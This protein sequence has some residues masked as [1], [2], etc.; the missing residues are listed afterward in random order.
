[1]NDMAETTPQPERAGA[2]GSTRLVLRHAADLLDEWAQYLREGA[3]AGGRW[4]DKSPEGIRA[5]QDWRDLKFTAIKLRRIATQNVQGE[6]R[7]AADDDVPFVSE[8]TGC[9]PFAPPCG[10]GDDEFGNTCP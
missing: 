5:R 9:P 4:I 10:L 3:T 2:V 1:M 6:R 8:R 7:G